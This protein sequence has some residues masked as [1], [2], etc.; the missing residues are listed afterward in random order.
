[1]KWAMVLGGLAI[2]GVGGFMYYQAT[3]KSDKLE[4]TKMPTSNGKP[5]STE[6]KISPL[7][8]STLQAAQVPPMLD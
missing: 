6:K 5:N 7:N 4:I 1:M 3:Q 8:V 2:A